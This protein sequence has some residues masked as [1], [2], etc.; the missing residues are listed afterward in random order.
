MNVPPVRARAR[1]KGIAQVLASG[2]CVAH[3]SRECP[4]HKCQLTA[5]ATTKSKMAT[6]APEDWATL[7]AIAAGRRRAHDVGFGSSDSTTSSARLDHFISQTRPLF[8]QT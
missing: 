1:R 7:P 5:N 3:G 6:R 2:L 4:D 8:S